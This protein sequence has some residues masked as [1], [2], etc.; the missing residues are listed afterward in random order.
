MEKWKDIK[1]YE[2]YYQ[3]SDL[4]NVRSLDRKD[5]RGYEWKGKIL[6][7]KINKNGYCFVA[8]SK[9]SKVSYPRVH[10]LVAEAFIPNPE[11]KRCVN[12]DDGNKSN[13]KIDNLFWATSSENNKHAYETGLKEPYLKL[14]QEEAE[15]IRKNYIP[16]HREFSYGALGKKF[17]VSAGCIRNVV[18]KKTYI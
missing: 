2:G 6:R 4:G 1:G 10:R 13:N 14:T 16:K 9:G 7:L 5:T 15:W 11:N 8:L 18:L 17:G 12:H 3:V